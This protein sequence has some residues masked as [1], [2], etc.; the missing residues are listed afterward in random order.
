MQGDDRLHAGGLNRR[1]ESAVVIERCVVELA[2][3]RLHARPSDGE[4]K[5]RATQLTRQ[6]DVFLEAVLEIGGL[7]AHDELVFALPHIADVLT[8]GVVGFALMVGRSGA[9]QERFGQ[10]RQGACTAKHGESVV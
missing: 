8:R 9:E 10:R 6:L 2:G 3:R 7:A 1:Q 5:R 4:T